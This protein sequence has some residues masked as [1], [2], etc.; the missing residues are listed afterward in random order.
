[1]QPARHDLVAGRLRCG[2]TPA[3]TNPHT[4]PP[5]RTQQRRACASWHTFG[6]HGTL[7]PYDGW[8]YATLPTVLPP[9]HTA[10]PRVLPTPPLYTMGSSLWTVDLPTLYGVGH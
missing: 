1:M 3:F 8:R 10:L 9:C 4:A 6:R 5:V 2:L 7:L